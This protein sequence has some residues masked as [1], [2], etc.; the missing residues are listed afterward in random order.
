MSYPP[1]DKELA[2]LPESNLTVRMLTLFDYIVPGAWINVTNLDD[3]IALVT[4]EEDED[5]IGQVRDRVIELYMDPNEKYHRAV[6][7][8]R[9]VDDVDKIVGAAAL[10]N[11]A[12]QQYSFLSFLDRFTPKADNAQ[13]VDACLKLVAELSTFCLINGLPGD[14]VMDFVK[15]LREY[16]KEDQMRI[17]TLV[18]AE[19][20]IPLGPDF[21]RMMYDGVHKID[22]DALTNN[23][24]FKS[25]AAFLPGDTAGEK[26]GLIRRTIDQAGDYLHGFAAERGITRESVDKRIRQVIDVG[27][28]G[29]DVV[30]ATIDMT[31]NYY[32]HTGI[33]SVA[34]S[35]VDRAYGEI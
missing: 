23:K 9:L 12:A 34:R 8:F 11:T 31:T 3:M 22:T 7:I 29:L 30:A 14:S 15:S 5:L 18:T 35:L 26:H 19:G 20:I 16:G 10:A 13:A 1:I 21:A 6:Q 24:L 32:E 17:A 2:Q 25:I 33:Q 27:D 28:K 4:E